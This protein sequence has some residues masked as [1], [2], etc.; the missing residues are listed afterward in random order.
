M[1]NV[2][3]FNYYRYNVYNIDLSL[4]PLNKFIFILFALYTKL[5]DV[6]NSY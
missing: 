1:Y 3:R 4:S 2:S 5:Y 6:L